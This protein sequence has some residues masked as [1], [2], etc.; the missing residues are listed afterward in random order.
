[1][2]L[3]PQVRRLK[4]RVL[5]RL[6]LLDQ[7]YLTAADRIVTVEGIPFRVRDEGPRNAPALVLIHGFSF[8][9]ESWDEWAAGLVPHYRVI[10]F[11]L[12]GHGLHGADPEGRSSSATRMRRILALMDALGIRRAS[13]PAT[14]MAACSWHIAAAHPRRVDELVLVDSAAWSINGVTESRPRSPGNA[15][16]SA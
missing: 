6:S 11:D 13:S 10:R 15:R 3:A 1:M 12:A 2:G 8:S 16:L 7:K 9:L 5:A 4:P 14:A